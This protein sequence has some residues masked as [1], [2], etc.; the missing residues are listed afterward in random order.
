MVSGRFRNQRV[1]VLMGGVSSEREVSLMS[2][3]AVC[4]ALQERGYTVVPIQVE[5]DLAWLGQVKKVDVVFIALHGKFSE[6]GSLQ[7][8]L[9]ILP[10]PYTGSGVLASALGMNKVLAKQ[11]WRSHGLPTPDWQVFH[12]GTH[13]ALSLPYPVVVKPNN[14]GSSVGVSIV[15]SPEV[16]WSALSEAFHYDP[17]AL[18]EEYIAGKEVTVG[19]LGERALGAMEVV[20]KGEFHT[21]EVKYTPGR[22][23]FILPA[24]VPAEVERQVLDLALLAHRSL[25]CEGYSRVDT[26]VTPAGEVFL[27]EVNTLPGFTTLSYLPKIAEYVGL[28]YADLVEEVLE[29]ASLK[30]QR[31]RL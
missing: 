20:A 15:H 6:D 28:S 2:G 7:G 24:P 17:E 10:V 4:Q 31:G 1:G 27:L 26:R 23:E 13:Q 5:A 29:R 30:T 14:E 22:E 18:A 19:I 3:Q 25:G 9:E 16:L 12:R 11:I 8:L 21:Y